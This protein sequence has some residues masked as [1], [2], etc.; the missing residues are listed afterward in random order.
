MNK[1][2]FILLPAAALLLAGCGGNNSSSSSSASSSASSSTSTEPV[3]PKAED[4]GTAENP[5]TVAQYL[6]NVERLVQKVDETYSEWPFYVKGVADAN[7][8]WDS[9]YSQYA[10]FYLKDK[11]SDSKSAKVQRAKPGTGVSQQLYGNDTVYLCGYAEYYSNGYSLFP[12]ANI[13]TGDV[14]VSKIERG[15]SKLSVTADPN[16]KA[17]VA[18]P[19]S[20]ESS[21]ENGTVISLQL[22]VE[23]G[24]LAFVEVNGVNLVADASGL[25][26]VTVAGDTSIKITSEKD[27]VRVDLP[28]GTYTLEI[29]NENSGLGEGKGGAV[30][31]NK[32]YALLADA[33]PNYYKRLTGA[34]S[35]LCYNQTNYGEWSI[36]KGGNA[37]FTTPTGKI[38]TAVADYYKN[39]SCD[40]YANSA[41]SGSKL[42][43]VKGTTSGDHVEYTYTVNNASVFFNV[44]TSASYAQSFYK[45]RLTIVVE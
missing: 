10:T 1:N 6:E 12:N 26:N 31:V 25:Y 7:A 13:D 34:Y 19:S 8:P 2:I 32:N 36:A 5:L 39:Q 24:Y 9:S 30:A 14:T 45:L 38:T 28:A 22:T 33:D 27:A 18:S 20:F 29:T 42:T 4:Y 16:G 17:V 40:V 11:V 3:G 44:S 21:Y 37:C 15:V 35:S 43:G 41:A 23:S